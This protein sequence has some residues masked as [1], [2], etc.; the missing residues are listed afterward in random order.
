MKGFSRISKHSNRSRQSK[1]CQMMGK[2]TLSLE[3]N[4]CRVLIRSHRGSREI[5]RLKSFY[6][7]MPRG[8]NYK[9]TRVSCRRKNRNKYLKI[10]SLRKSLRSLSSL[11]STDLTLISKLCLK[12]LNSMKMT[13]FN[14]NQLLRSLPKWDSWE[15]RYLLQR[16]N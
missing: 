9:R 8:D 5:K 4:L 3:R 1:Y 7:V 10:R 16:S 14:R 6:W 13:L 15:R 12:D 11:F 2:E